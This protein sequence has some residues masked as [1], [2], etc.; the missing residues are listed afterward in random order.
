MFHV[1]STTSGIVVRFRED[2]E[3]RG[4][5]QEAS[6]RIVVYRE[7]VVQL[8]ND[9]LE[10]FRK[11]GVNLPSESTPR[12]A[13]ELVRRQLGSDI[14]AAVEQMVDNFEVAD[15]SLHDILRD[16]YISMYMACRQLTEMGG[17]VD[18]ISV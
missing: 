9:S 8:Y 11:R 2:K 4:T 12:E 13:E 7:E 14:E 6:L 15:Y 18:E 17:P 10:G 3:Y 5:S 16:S 1:I